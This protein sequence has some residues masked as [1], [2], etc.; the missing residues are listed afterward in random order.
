MSMQYYNKIGSIDFSNGLCSFKSKS[1]KV[2]SN[3][4]FKVVYPNYVDN[5]N[6]TDRFYINSTTESSNK[7]KQSYSK[8]NENQNKN[9]LINIPLVHSLVDQNETLKFASFNAQSL[10]RTCQQKRILLNEFI[11]DEAI[12]LMFIQET[13]F[14]SSGDEGICSELAPPN[15]TAVSFPRSYHGGGLALVYRKSLERH[16]S[17][18]TNFDFSH[19]SFELFQL[20]LKS[21]HHSVVFYN[22]Y[23]TIPRKNK[24]NIS[25][26]DF[27]EEFH[28]LLDSCNQNVNSKLIILGDFN[29]HFDQPKN[30]NTTKMI[31]LL[32]IFD[33]VQLVK[34][35]TQKSGHILDWVITRKSE[36][37]CLNTKIIHDLISDHNCI[38]CE[39]SIS[40]FNHNSNTSIFRNIKKI[41]RNGFR[42]DLISSLNTSCK[43]IED[44]NNVLT[45]LLDYHAPKVHLKLRPDRDPVDDSVKD[46]LIQ[47]K[48]ERRSAEK[49]WLKTG[50]TVHKE[51]FEIRKRNVAKLVQHGRSKYYNSKIVN[52]N[53]NK[54]LYDICKSLTG[55]CNSFSLPS[56]DMYEN[57]SESFSDFFM[58]KIDTIRKELDEMSKKASIIPSNTTSPISHAKFDSFLSVAEDQVKKFLLESKPTT[59]P[60]DP[61]PTKFLLEFVDEIVPTLTHLIN[62]SL[63]NGYFPDT[64]KAAVVRPLLK[65]PSLDQNNLKN[66]RPIS[67][68]SFISKIFEKVVLSQLFPFLHEN[69]LLSPNQSAYRSGHSTETALVKVL[70][71][72]LLSLDQGNTSI[73]TLLDLSSAFDTIDHTILINTLENEFNITGKVLSWFKSYLSLRHQTVMINNT[74]SSSKTLKY[75][76][77]QGSVLG[78]IL[79]II[80]TKSLHD[81]ISKHS[82]HDQSFADDT[83]LYHSS[84][85]NAIHNSITSIGDCFTEIK[86]WMTEHKLKLNE[87][88]TEAILF[89]S[90]NSFDKHIK[91]SSISIGSSVIPFSQNVRNLGFIMSENVS[92]D[93][94]INSICKSAYAALRRI[95]AI[96]KYLTVHATTV[97]VCS[98]VLS[99][100]DYGNALLINSPKSSI[101]KLQK[102]QNAAA[103]LISKT[104][105]Y[106]HITPVL[107]NLHWL[108]IHLRIQYK[109]LVLCFN[110]FLG[111][112]PSYISGILSVYIP[113]RLLRSSSDNRILQVPSINTKKYGQRAFSHAAPKLWNALPYSLR[114]LNTTAAFKRQLKTYLFKNYYQV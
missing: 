98:F 8:H 95:S 94:H 45:Q 1:L 61:M 4:D 100:L 93:A 87:N 52:S 38:L 65:K 27:I 106:D 110:F 101:L 99:R 66:Y 114:H 28:H 88:K 11:K 109:I 76:V 103:R 46:E 7:I 35:P 71:D 58:S 89:H 96:R 54:E 80:Y 113:K 14:N 108:P 60:L 105:K 81:L 111:L 9:N 44:F 53:T 40:K 84:P 82:I 17:I 83:Q 24:N 41:D 102:V 91:P 5:S 20:T 49:K 97:L 29:Y 43:T 16:I 107:K 32:D 78:P 51:I 33:L 92:S 21:L 39:L 50:L 22:I 57:I 12:D 75:G 19:K 10:G 64:L 72:I 68:L 112:S 90:S 30:P 69:K 26:G 3:N 42:T 85:P 59:C 18:K 23:R 48:K 6:H 34:S 55:G 67:T 74:S 13:W 31:D 56:A 73:L 15:Y 63:S 36:D 86:T 47:K 104:R 77:P 70:N 79:F 62:D 37:A 2:F 25:E